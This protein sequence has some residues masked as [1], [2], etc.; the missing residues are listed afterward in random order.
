VIINV[1][2]KSK[3]VRSKG[4]KVKLWIVLPDLHHP[5]YDGPSWTAVLHFLK[6]NRVDGVVF[7]GDNLDCANISRHT[8][9]KP[10]LRKRGG[11]QDDIDTFKAEI[12]N[13][14][15]ALLPRNCKKIFFF[16]NHEAW[17]EQFLD[18]NP[19]LEGALD[20]SKNLEL[21]ERGWHIIPQGEHYKI[22][23]ILLMHGD[24]IGSSMHVAKKMV[25]ECCRICLMG[26]VHRF[27]A[28]TKVGVEPEDK[29]VGM[30]LPCMSSLSPSYAKGRHNAFLHGFGI[31][32]SWGWHRANIY[33]PIITKG[34]FC[35]GGRI[36]GRS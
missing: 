16:G 23:H 17:Q 36:Y 15:E 35:Y 4:K 34:Q 21:I 3:R 22:D 7:L 33:V 5:H 2:L 27:S 1:K 13:P 30:T 12:L 31:I 18:E 9:G 10:R 25:D 11:Y 6:Y 32:E 28:Y 26:H 8:V 20:I 29:W 14:L 19:E 24:Q